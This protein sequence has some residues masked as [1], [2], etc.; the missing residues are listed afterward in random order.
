MY[1][2]VVSKSP[3]PAPTPAANGKD[4]KDQKDQARVTYPWDNVHFLEVPASGKVSRA[5]AV[6]PGDYEVF[7]TVKEATPKDQAEECAASEDRHAA[8]GR[9]RPRFHQ[10]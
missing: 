1:V 10:A 6:K 5:L 9:Q 8:Q 2:R 7:I 3:A 4:Q